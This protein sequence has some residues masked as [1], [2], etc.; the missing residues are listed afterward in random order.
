M[1]H[2]FYKCWLLKSWEEWFRLL[3]GHWWL[4]R[5]IWTEDCFVIA[6]FCCGVKGTV[7]TYM[8]ITAIR[9]GTP[10]SVL[11]IPLA[12]NESLTAW[13]LLW[14]QIVWAGGRIRANSQSFDWW[15]RLKQWVQRLALAWLVNAKFQS[16]LNNRPFAYGLGGSLLSKSLIICQP[17]IVVIFLTGLQHKDLVAHQI[18]YPLGLR[19]NWS[20]KVVGG[21]SKST[22]ARWN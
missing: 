20:D 5:G 4:G 17:P 10:L 15:N 22:L 16:E 18:W 2:V 19:L 9:K 3:L 21:V 8:L 6:V 14:W 12:T 13:S 1:S 7:I 11:F